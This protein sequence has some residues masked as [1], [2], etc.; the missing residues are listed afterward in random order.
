MA[1]DRPLEGYC[2]LLLEDELFIAATV[3]EHL[4]LA[5]AQQVEVAATVAAAEASLAETSFDAAILDILVPDGDAR[6]LAE[7]LV[8]K[9]VRVI[10]HSGHS[11]PDWLTGPLEGA[12][13]LQKPNEP[14]AIVAAVQGKPHDI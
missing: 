3:R 5:G 8:E 10:F 13:F 14:E 1:D 4:A 11:R 12:V 6:T 9:G 7:G 2:V